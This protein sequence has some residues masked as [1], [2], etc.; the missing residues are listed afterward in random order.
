M[1]IDM[2]QYN[3]RSRYL[4]VINENTHVSVYKY[5]KCKF[6][7]PF[8]SFQPQNIFIVKSK[9]CALTQMSNALD[10][11][12]FDGNT[13][14]LEF[15][16]NKYVYISG[17]EIF[18]F[19]TNDKISDYISLIG[20]NMIPYTYAIG[21]KYTYFISDRYKF[22]ENEKIEEGS[23]LNTLNPYEYHLSKNGIDSFKKLI[24]C[25]RIH[26]TCSWLTIEGDME[27]IVDH[28][29]DEEDNDIHDL[30]YTNGN[31][32]VIKIFNQKC[33]ICLERDSEYIF[34]QC[35]HQCICEQCYLN[36]GDIDILK[37]VICR[38]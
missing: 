21:S 37:C 1:H 20:N 17:S 38:T 16:D 11:S 30:E 27:E 9:D 31:N 19:E 15:N 35:G 36:K 2:I 8:L 23:L 4:D 22:I 26:S 24:D 3:Y 34:K 32:E 12:D 28:E 5:E 6:D 7:E 29:E 13:I 10:N 33:V 25:K 14:L 18:G